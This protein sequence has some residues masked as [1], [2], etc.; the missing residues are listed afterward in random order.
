MAGRFKRRVVTAITL[1]WAL[2][3]LVGGFVPAQ[4]SVAPGWRIVKVIGPQGGA[5]G[6]RGISASGPDNAW[7]TGT[8][9]TKGCAHYVLL[10]QHWNGKVWSAVSPPSAMTTGTSSFVVGTS[11]PSNVWIFTSILNS[12]GREYALHLSGRKWTRSALPVDAYVT[13]TAVFS[14]RDAWAF[15]S[16]YAGPKYGQPYVIRYDGRSWRNVVTPAVPIAVSAVSPSDIWAS[17]QI[18]KPGKSTFDHFAMHWNGHSWR[19][20]SFPKIGAPKGW[21]ASVFVALGLGPSNVWAQYS[22]SNQTT[23]E[24]CKAGGLLHWNGSAWRKF[25]VPKYIS[26][27]AG[28]VTSDGHGGLWLEAGGN[29]VSMFDYVNGRWHR[30]AVPGG[31][32]E[33]VSS[34]N[35]AAV[36]GTRSVWGGSAISPV[37][38]HGGEWQSVIVRY[39]P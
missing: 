9:C 28:N 15:G 2:L 36:P 21:T 39:T 8:S 1:V 4:A 38:A 3:P 12:D 13:R 10:V 19:K 20:L 30:Y 35:L 18:A 24:C 7:A 32:T 23:P 11:S 25:P 14:S 34:L 33:S 31:T 17:F 29:T 16:Y 22:Y 5:D 27:L 37:S 6:I 26:Y